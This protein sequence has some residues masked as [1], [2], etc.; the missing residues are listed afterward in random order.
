MAYL[1]SGEQSIH[2]SFEEKFHHDCWY[3]PFDDFDS[4]IT[5]NGD[6][7]VYLSGGGGGVIE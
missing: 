6:F 1:S 5:L 7:T 4:D 2:Y 3:D